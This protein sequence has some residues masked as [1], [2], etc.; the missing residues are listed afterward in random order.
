MRVR[1]DETWQHG[2]SAEIDLSNARRRE[3]HH[4]RIFA[5]CE[6]PAMRYRH[7]FSNRVGWIHRHDVAVMQNEFRFFLFEWKE[8]ESGNRAYKPT[9]SRSLSHCAS[10]SLI[11]ER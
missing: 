1:V 3:I 9:A 10:P 7:S 11:G 4:V 2:L 5:N 8:R 6:K